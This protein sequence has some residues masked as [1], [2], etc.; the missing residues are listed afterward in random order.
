MLGVKPGS[1]NPFC[2]LND[3]DKKFVFYMDAEL[4][5][6]EYIN[7]HPMDN[8]FTVHLR[9]E[10]LLGFLEKHG[11]RLPRPYDIK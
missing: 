2:L 7:V 6:T 3:A 10:D 1:V 5:N 9:L 4:Q 11:Q 8:R